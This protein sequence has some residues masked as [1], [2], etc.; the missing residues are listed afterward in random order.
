MQTRRPFCCLHAGL[1]GGYVE[2][3]VIDEKK[4]AAVSYGQV[5]LALIGDS[6]EIITDVKSLALADN[7]IDENYLL[8]FEGKAVKNG[9]AST[10]T[11]ADYSSADEYTVWFNV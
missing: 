5:L 1:F 6:S 10:V 8:K 4:V 3:G 7:L 9:E 11:L 2:T